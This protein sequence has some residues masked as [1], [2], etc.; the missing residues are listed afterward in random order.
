VR[1]VDAD[2]HAAVAVKGHDYDHADV[3]LH[4]N[5]GRSSSVK[6]RRET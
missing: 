3:N 5:A 4:V 6:S 2:V 1:P